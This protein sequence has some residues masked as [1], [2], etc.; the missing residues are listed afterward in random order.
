MQAASRPWGSLGCCPEKHG[1]KRKRSAPTS[2]AHAAASLSR[3]LWPTRKER[4]TRDI[5]LGDLD[6]EADMPLIAGPTPRAQSECW[7]RR[8]HVIGIAVGAVL[9][10][11]LGAGLAVA[12]LLARGGE[13]RATKAAVAAIA[14][15]APEASAVPLPHLPRS[16]RRSSSGGSGSSAEH[17]DLNVQ[18]GRAAAE[19]MRGARDLLRSSAELSTFLEVYAARPDR[20]NVCA[21]RLTHAFALWSIVRQLQPTT[22]IVTEMAAAAIEPPQLPLRMCDAYA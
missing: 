4:V 22:I 13:D 3:M 1:K 17:D 19:V 9:L 16:Q 8:W 18:W 7:R 12:I 20:N 21:I 5:A 6:D 11:S 15:A 10:M 14:A 2:G